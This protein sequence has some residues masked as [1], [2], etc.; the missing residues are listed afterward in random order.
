MAG[1]GRDVVHASVSHALGDHVDHLV[2]TG[3]APVTGVG[4]SLANRLTGNAYDTI[5]RGACGADTIVGGAGHDSLFG[6]V[7]NDVL[8]CGAGNGI[9]SG[10]AGRDASDS[11]AGNDTLIGG[12]G[13]DLLS[14][15]ARADVFVFRLRSDRNVILDFQDDIDAIRLVDLG[16]PV[17]TKHGHMPRKMAPMSSLIS[18]MATA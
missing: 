4:N 1:G 13:R 15:G 17:L 10:G 11:R 16:T 12:A 8:N 9:F 2:M 5:L 6:G 3:S 7:G 18:G 14:G